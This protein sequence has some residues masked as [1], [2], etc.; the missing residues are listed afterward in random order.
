MLYSI[1]K[2]ECLEKLIELVALENQ[3]KELPLQDKLDKQ[4]F[5]EM[6]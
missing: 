4:N 2:R 1:E 5:H 6:Y 3:V